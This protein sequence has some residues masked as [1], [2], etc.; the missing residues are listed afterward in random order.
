MASLLIGVPI[1]LVSVGS[2]LYVM[3]DSFRKADDI[4][5]VLEGPLTKLVD[6]TTLRT[7]WAGAIADPGQTP[8]QELLQALSIHPH[9]D[10]DY[11]EED[12]GI[13][14]QLGLTYHRYK[15]HYFGDST[16]IEPAV[17]DGERNGRQV[18]IRLGQSYKTVWGP[19][20]GMRRMRH[21]VALRIAA[22]TFEL[23]AAGGRL[24][25]DAVPPAVAAMLAAM[26]PSPDVWH[27]LRLVAGPDGVVINR[28]YAND[29]S[30]GWPYDLWL[31][32]RIAAVLDAPSLPH[33]EELGR[34]WDAPY[35]LG[36]WAPSFR[37]TVGV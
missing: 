36:E 16:Q 15:T 10:A 3:R 22:P 26:A 33:V 20:A 27:D 31:V 19:G 29:L 24:V 11:D 4:Q 23:N 6:V 17:F 8:S 1:L 7:N 2:M 34:E 28:G 14:R 13:G 37:D 12:E 30:G 18:W 35:G 25:G 21:I 5:R 9:V 32:E